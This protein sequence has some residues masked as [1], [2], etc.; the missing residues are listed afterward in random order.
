MAAAVVLL[1]LV[2]AACAAADMAPAEAPVAPQPT[3]PEEEPLEPEPTGAPEEPLEPQPTDAPEEPEATATPAA[4]GPMPSPTPIVEERRAEIE[5]PGS[6]RVGDG[7][8]IRLSLVSGPGGSML[9]TPDIEGHQVETTTVPLSVTRPGYNGFLCASLSAAGLEVAAASPAEQPLE[10]GGSNTW[11]WTI[12]TARPGTYRPIASLSVRWEPQPG[13][14][15]PGPLE[16]AVWSRVLTVKARALLGL[17]G[18]QVDLLGV[19]GS[20]LGTVA[21]L[22]FLEKAVTTLW[23]RLRR[24]RPEEM[25]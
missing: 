17:S 25:A 22:P 6:M 13:A 15:V 19:G 16:E 2:V 12:S 8:V 21:G 1:A 11:Y 10:P 24:R 3:G 14:D 4:V 23:R 9:A 18:P 20:V 5:W 7:E